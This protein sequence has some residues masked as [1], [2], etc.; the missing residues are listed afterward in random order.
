MGIPMVKCAICGQDVSKRQSMLIEPFGRICR[1]HPEVEEHK[2][3]LAEIEAKTKAD[4]RLADGLRSFQVMTIVEQIR[5]TAKI[6]GQSLSLVT[7]V[8][9]YRLPKGIREEVEKGVRERGPVSDKEMDEAIHMAAYMATRGFFKDT[10]I[11]KPDTKEEVPATKEEIQSLEETLPLW[12]D[13]PKKDEEGGIYKYVRFADG[14]VLFVKTSGYGCASHKDI[15][16]CGY[17]HP[18]IKDDPVSGLKPPA[19]SAGKITVRCRDGKRIWC[20]SES[21]STSAKL[22]RCETDEKYIQKELGSG[23]VENVEAQY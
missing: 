19:V 5:M 18:T 4:K 22:P 2:A 3:K 15:V 10:D 13:D 1:S 12:L 21:G 17:T 23:F 11:S 8:V 14:K 20:V 7:T 9:C 16:D 6:S